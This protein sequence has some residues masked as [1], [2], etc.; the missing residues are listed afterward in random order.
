MFRKFLL[1]SILSLTSIDLNAQTRPKILDEVLVKAKKE[2][3]SLTVPSVAE[4]K[5]ELA[6]DPGGV[7]VI[8][9]KRYLTGRASTLADTFFLSPGVVAQS[10]FGS[11]E[12]RISIRGSGLQRTFHG[13]GIRLLQDGIPLNLADGGFD[14]QAIEPTAANYINVWR[15]G[16][17]LAYGSSTLGGAI[18]YISKT[19]ASHPDAFLRAEAGSYDYYRTTVGGGFEKDI[20]D[21]YASFTQQ[22]Q[23]GFRDHTEQNNQR[24]FSNFGIKINDQLETRF[25]FSTVKTDSELPGSLT[26]AQ[27][28]RDP[29]QANI[30]SV[31][32]DQHRDFDLVR[33][34][35][36]TTF[37]NGN[38]TFDLTA[39]W[40]Y[41]DLNHPIFNLVD[42]LSNDLVLGASVTNAADIFSRENRLKAG[43][44]FTRGQTRANQ[45]GYVGATGQKKGNLISF[46]DQTATNIEGYVEDQLSLGAGFTGILGASV[47]HNTRK[48][49]NRFPRTNPL[50]SYDLDYNNISPK[51]GA[52][53]DNSEKDIQVFANFSGSYEPPSFS[54]SVTANVARKAQKANTFEIGTRGNKSFVHWDTTA[55]YSKIE[56]ELLAVVDPITNL[57]T[58]TNTKKTTHAGL[59]IGSEID[60]FG[61]NWNDNVNDRLVCATSWT[62]GRFT[63]DEQRTSAY[64]YSRNTIAGLPQHLIH[65]ELLWKNAAGYYA[66]PT[67]DWVPQDYFIDHRNTFSADGY[68]TVGFKFGRRVDEGISWFIEAKNLTNEVYASTTGVIDNANGA[69]Q[70]QFLPGDGRSIFAGI[71]AKF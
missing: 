64:D 51:I 45:F 71:E 63:F 58:T 47:S 3:L 56:D 2:N 60:L 7:E 67:G 11:D 31:N 14:M 69:D 22:S 15:G 49:E 16:N 50:A 66:G 27:L 32:R 12:A 44:F 19:G 6:K 26:K 17:A 33:L 18:D 48:N 5:E 20:V 21:V 52:R 30:A 57:S 25:Y 29:R 13:R 36:K 38:N 41:K 53:W 28:E 1:L 54:E 62:Y 70:A 43:V 68:T 10:R 8:D 61:Q 55:Y 35:N 24:F 42:Q 34:A 40:T 59:E 23:G 9:S 4:S 46:N 65:A 39:A 37:R